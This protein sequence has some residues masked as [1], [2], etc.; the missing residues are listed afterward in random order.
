M[1][2]YGEFLL[3]DLKT[4]DSMYVQMFILGK[5]DSRYFEPVVSSLYSR[6]YRLKI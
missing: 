3:V 4:F 6:I 2:S 5:Y 1:S